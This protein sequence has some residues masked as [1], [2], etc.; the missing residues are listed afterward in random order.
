VWDIYGAANDLDLYVEWAKLI[1]QGGSDA[2]ASRRRAAGMIALR[3]DRDG[4]ITGYDGVEEI[5]QAYGSHIHDLHLPPAGT[6]TQGVEGGYMANAWV[7]M[8]HPDY[9]QLRAMLD[10]VGETV[11]VHA[12]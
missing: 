7:R 2:K 8:L 10:K 12:S 6:A 5:Q 3:P 9:D 1:V 4:R 11:K